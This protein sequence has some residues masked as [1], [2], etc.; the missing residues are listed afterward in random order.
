MKDVTNF[1]SVQDAVQSFAPGEPAVLYFPA[2]VY[3][4]TQ[5]LEFAGRTVILRGDGQDAT[6][7]RF[8]TD[9]AH[10]IRVDNSSA[11]G[12]Q[13][14]IY[15]GDMS[16]TTTS[17]A[18]GNAIEIRYEPNF[19]QRWK[20]RGLL[21]NMEI[22]GVT[23]FDGWQHGVVYNEGVNLSISHV[24]F[25]GKH[26]Q[27]DQSAAANTK[28]TLQSFGR[29]TGRRASFMSQTAFSLHGKSASTLVSAVKASTSSNAPFCSAGSGFAGIST[30]QRTGGDHCSS[31][32]TAQL[33][34][35]DS[36]FYL[37][38]VVESTI[39]DN[40]IYLN[41]HA[42]DGHAIVLNGCGTTTVH[43]NVLHSFQ[44]QCN[45]IILTGGSQYCDVSA[46]I[47]TGNKKSDMPD[48]NWDTGIWLQ[49]GCAY[50]TVADNSFYE[51]SRFTEIFDEGTENVVRTL[52]PGVR[53]SR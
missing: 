38:F 16:V 6:E 48:W 18:V 29:V 21:Y 31:R 30:S 10:G 41:D 49:Q 4:L 8:V 3:F 40:L 20:G 50:N 46:N 36:A 12:N 47:F 26:D 34:I 33:N 2:G 25:L 39:H 32:A 51:E 13:Y 35:Y 5:A 44:Q 1:P 24:S 53:V 11:S 9:L 43:H 27:T 22:R 15:I 37:A 23:H 17:D 14:A 52:H 42:I 19:N 45:G 7:L 28:V